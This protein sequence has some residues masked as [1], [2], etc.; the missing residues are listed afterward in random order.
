MRR[1]LTTMLLAALALTL[2]GQTAR[3][4]T[5]NI[6][7]DGASNMVGYLPDQPSSY[8]NLDQ[9]FFSD[10]NHFR[11]PLCVSHEAK[12]ASARDVL[13]NAK[14]HNANHLNGLWTSPS[15]AK[16]ARRTSGI[17]RLYSQRV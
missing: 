4:F 14:A 9:V 15:M 2:W 11:Q 10:V 7:P 17:E 12:V 16:E 3:K 1:K 5:V 6:T 13:A 8:E